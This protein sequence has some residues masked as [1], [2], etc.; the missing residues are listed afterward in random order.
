ML[1]WRRAGLAVVFL[2]FMG[3]GIAHFVSPDFFVSI[4]PPYIGFQLEIVYLSGVLEILG[5]IGIMLPQWRTRAGNGLFVLT[6]FVTPANVHM[7]RNP[8]LFPDV[9]ESFLSVRLLI[10]VLLLACIWF[11]TRTSEVTEEPD[12]SEAAL[13]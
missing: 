7:W 13:G 6:I 2:W 3:G 8:D 4:M 12:S 9:P 10:Q 1:W 11:A 5:A